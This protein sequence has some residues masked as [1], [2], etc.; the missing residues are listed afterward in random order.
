MR[1]VIDHLNSKF[2]E[3]LSN[4]GG[5]SI[6]EHSEIQRQVWNEA[7]HKIKTNKIGFQ[8]LVLRKSG[9]LYQIDIYLGRK[10]TPADE[11]L[12]VIILHCLFWQLFLIEKLF[13]KCI[14]GIGIFW[15]Y[16]NQ[17]PKMIDDKQ[18]TIAIQVIQWLANE[19]IIGQHCF[20]PLPLREWMTYYQF[21]GEKSVQRPSLQFLVPRLSSFAITA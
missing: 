13:Q 11:R 17:M 16:R 14:Y 7:V 2:S 4:E 6:D 9:Y 15:A 21:R 12:S 20:Y 3:V 5:Q 18:M 10:Q 1:P 19:W 8:I